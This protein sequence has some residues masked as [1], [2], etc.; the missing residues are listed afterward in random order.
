M[1]ARKLTDLSIVIPVYNEIDNLVPLDNEL[2]ISLS[3]MQG[4]T[5]EVIYVDDGSNDGSITKLREIVSTS[6]HRKLVEFTRNFGQTPALYCG[7]Q[8][9]VGEIVIALDA[10]LQ[11]DPVDIPR[12]YEA[13]ISGSD[14][15][16][17]WRKSR[18]DK[19]ISRKLPSWIANRLLAKATGVLIH[20]SGCTLKGYNGELIRS[21]PLYGEMHRLIPFYVFLAGGSISE[22]E[23]NHRMRIHGKSKY[24][25]SRTFRVIQDI[26]V[27]RVQ[28]EFA[29]RPMH[30]FGNLGM[31][32]LLLG[33]LLFLTAVALKLFG[34]RNFVET[35]LPTLSSLFVLAGL[36]IIAVGL[37]AEIVIR[38]MTL[39]GESRIYR[40]KK[41]SGSKPN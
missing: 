6:P 28:A 18:Q 8:E 25:I 3:K 15:V 24:G 1:R 7:F 41:R 13:V 35:P 21:I 2:S 29:M 23:V 14:C 33:F 5:Y 4:I 22:I 34:L 39:G 16:S 31:G 37:L 9:S 30:L 26:I 32:S 38:R 20:D 17:G 40:I 10:D 19:G 36:Q 11:N 12:I 27:A